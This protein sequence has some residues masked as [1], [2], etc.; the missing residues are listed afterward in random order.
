MTCKKC[1]LDEIKPVVSFNG[2]IFIK[3][4]STRRKVNN[5]LGLLSF[6]NTLSSPSPEIKP[7]KLVQDVQ[8]FEDD[9]R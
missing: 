7:G 8:G 6:R 1:G 9:G 2:T 4:T 5:K 3:E